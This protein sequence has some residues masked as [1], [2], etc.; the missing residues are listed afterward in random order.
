MIILTRFRHLV[1]L[2]QASRPDVNRRFRAGMFVANRGGTVAGGAFF[3]LSRPVVLTLVRASVLV[4]ALLF[5][6]RDLW[7]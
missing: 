2:V 3:F 5:E 4:T 7:E 6:I 1:D